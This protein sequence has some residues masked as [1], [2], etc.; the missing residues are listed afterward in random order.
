MLN[1]INSLFKSATITVIGIYID[2]LI[3]SKCQLNTTPII[4]LL[5]LAINLL[6]MKR[7]FDKEFD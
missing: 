6:V 3:Q 7:D 5:V 1:A 4:F 2:R